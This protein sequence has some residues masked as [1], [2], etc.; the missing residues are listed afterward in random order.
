M[1]TDRPHLNQAELILCEELQDRR[2]PFGMLD[3]VLTEAIAWADHH[4]ARW[5]MPH[6]DDTRGQLVY[7]IALT[8]RRLRGRGT[9]TVFAVRELRRLL[10]RSTRPHPA[11]VD[12]AA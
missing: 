12:D 4:R 11:E 7:S 10:T 3:E 8:L 1:T 9:E 6:K 5:P 2:V